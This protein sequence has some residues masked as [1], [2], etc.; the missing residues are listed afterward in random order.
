VV[1]ARSSRFLLLTNRLEQGENDSNPLKQDVWMAPRPPEPVLSPGATEPSGYQ[2][3]DP[4]PPWQWRVAANATFGNAIELVGADFPEVVRRPGN[5]PLS[6][7]FRVNKKPPG[8]FRIFVHFDTPGEPRLIG[9]H[10]PLNGAFATEYWLPGEYIRDTYN[11]EVPLMT[12]PAGTYTLWVGFWPGGEG[13][14]IKITA[15]N[16]DG[17]DRTK[18]GIIEIK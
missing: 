1:D 2:W 7:Y 4:K 13:K 17:V 3:F 8:G 6:L 10:A 15:G 5:I 16:N 18:L 11:V 9:D 12:T 14:R